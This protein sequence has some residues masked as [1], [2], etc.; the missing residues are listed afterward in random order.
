MHGY[1]TFDGIITDEKRLY[2]ATKKTCKQFD[3]I[4]NEF[5][6]AA[7][8]HSDAPLFSDD[9][10]YRGNRCNHMRHVLLL[11]L[12]SEKL[13]ITRDGFS[14]I[15]DV[16]QSTISRYLEFAK[17]ILLEI[18]PTA[19][20]ITQILRNARTIEEIKHL[21]PGSNGGELYIDGTHISIERPSDLAASEGYYA[22]R[23]KKHTLN[24]TIGPIATS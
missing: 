2:K 24:I 9:M 3:Y 15:F 18:L 12:M 16:D 6:E 4:L 7:K 19:E 22:G 17:T 5:T 1:E 10:V 13:G 8:K 20:K 23:K 14:S 21:V 11:A